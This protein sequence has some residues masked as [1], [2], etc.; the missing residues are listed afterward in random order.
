MAHAMIRLA[1]CGAL[2]LA[3]CRDPRGATADAP[4]GGPADG[5]ATSLDAALD[6][7]PDAPGIPFNCTTDTTIHFAVHPVTADPIPDGRLVILV[8]Q[9]IDNLHVTPYI[10]YDVP[11][12]GT[13]TSLDF[14]L[15]DLALPAMLDDYYLCQRTCFDL[16]NP[17]CDC[18]ALAPKIALGFVAVVSD[19]DHSGAIEQAE[20]TQANRYGVGVMQLGQ[21]DRAYPAPTVLDQLAPDGIQGCVAPYSILPADAGHQFD[22]IGIP[23]TTTFSLDVCVPGSAACSMLRV[24][25]LT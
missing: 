7:P 19:L 4:T 17:A 20:L 18:P 16:A 15:A 23:T 13:S 9:F 5:S 22:R 6:A 2:A 14:A 1:L 3:G 8:Y 11:F 12:I 24:P 10:G 25:N 21:S